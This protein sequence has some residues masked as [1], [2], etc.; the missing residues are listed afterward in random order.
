M[1]KYVTAIAISILVAPYNT[2][3]ASI[4]AAEACAFNFTDD[5]GKHYD[6]EDFALHS[7]VAEVVGDQMAVFYD[8][9][10]DE[11]S[12]EPSQLRDMALTNILQEGGQSM[13][14]YPIY[15]SAIAFEPGLWDSTDGLEEGVTY[16]AAS[17]ACIEDISYC[18][19]EASID[20]LQV[21][22]LKTNYNGASIYSPYAFRGPPNEIIYTNCSRSQPQYCPSMDLAFGYDYS[23]VATPEAKWY[24]APRCLYLRDG[25]TTGYWTSPYF[26]SGAG[27]INMVTYSQP[28]ISK[29]GKFL[30]VA[31][32][33]VTVDALCYGEQCNES[34][35]YS[36]SIQ[37]VGLTMSAI[38]MALSLSFGLVKV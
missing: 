24:N 11:W 32:I 7:R 14:Q 31:T 29:S 2:V 28:I 23:N 37:P 34:V 27:N 5:Q 4:T 12:I 10:N 1:L 21:I 22:E 30:G 16:P 8:D 18:T 20:N 36:S 15:G 3:S 17:E 33:D 35:D 6:T 25:T 19:D 13:Q 38:V 26:D 9:D